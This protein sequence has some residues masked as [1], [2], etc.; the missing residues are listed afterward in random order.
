MC[1]S[2]KY[3]CVVTQP[4]DFG[5]GSIKTCSRTHLP[6]Y[7]RELSWGSGSPPTTPSSTSPLSH[8]RINNGQSFV[9]INRKALPLTCYCRC[10]KNPNLVRKL[11][12]G[13]EWSRRRQM[14]LQGLA[15]FRMTVSM[16]FVDTSGCH[17]VY[18]MTGTYHW[19][20]DPAKPCWLRLCSPESKNKMHTFRNRNR[21]REK[22][23]LLVQRKKETKRVSCII[24]QENHRCEYL[25]FHVLKQLPGKLMFALN[26]TNTPYDK[27]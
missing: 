8:L 15:H 23:V 11:I 4:F 2:A 13:L 1:L 27:L 14:Y 16:S 20:D 21:N 25:Y 19:S 6:N 22:M 9:N 12:C 3:V 18:W 7:R 10:S 26:K 17:G 24:T 5:W